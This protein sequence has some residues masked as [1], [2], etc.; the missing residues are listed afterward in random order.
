MGTSLANTTPLQFSPTGVTD[1][2]DATNAPKGAMA[3]LTNLIPDPTSKNLWQCRP[4]AT[5]LIDF[6]TRGGAFSSAFSSAFAIGFAPGAGFISC[7]KNVGTRIYGMIA[8][9]TTPGH[10]EPFCYDVEA[11][12][13]IKVNGVTGANTPISPPSSGAWTPPI[14]EI[15]G[16]KL[17]V[18]HPGFNGTGGNYFGW[19]DI[20]D[21]NNLTWAAGNVSGGVTFTTAPTWIKQFN[22]RAYYG[23]NPSTGQPSVVYSDVLVPLVVTNANQVLTF[24]D[25]VPLTAAAGLPL[26]NQLGGIVQSLIVFKGITN[27]YQVTGDAATN[28]L[29]VNTL[30]VAT[31]TLSPLSI[32]STPKGLSFVAPDGIRF[33]DFDANVSDPLGVAGFG[34]TLPFIF[35]NVPSRVCMAANASVLRVSVQN[36]GV[37]GTPNQEWWY[38]FTTPRQ[39]WSGPHT[40]PSSLIV[41]YN[42]TFI[43][44]PIEATASL[45]MSDTVQST[46]S[47]YVENG[48]QLTWTFQTALLPDTLQMSENNILEATLNI[49]LASGINVSVYAADE[50]GTVFDTVSVTPAGSAT[51][52]GAFQ[53]GHALWQGSSDALAP[54]QLNWS[55]PIVFRRMYLTASA[56]SAAGIKVGDAFLRYEILG[57][58]QQVA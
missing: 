21:P 50:N 33:I 13:I 48:T 11:G 34:V 9:S 29:L 32:C 37:V 56:E 8:T 53:W 38:D 4:A 47:T 44:T 46:S 52:W 1:T 23:I 20:S 27:M 26:F 40:F 51:I 12:V 41:V 3:A 36:S 6:T 35:S 42:K 24:G 10:D 39:C 28:N 2:L 30:N 49:A 5:R 14:M 22:G 16:T 19:F 54:R 17:L 58:L 31:G 55:I 7:M 15:V 43:K 45:W 57:Y 18:A 25:N